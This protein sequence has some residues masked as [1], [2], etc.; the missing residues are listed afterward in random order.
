MPRIVLLSDTH[1]CNGDI[2][3]HAGDATNHG[4]LAEIAA[5]NLW[6]NALPH[7]HK[8]FVAGNHDRLFEERPEIAQNLLHSSIVYLQDAAVEIEGLKIY[9]SPW[10]P[11]FFDWAFNLP[12]GA[13]LAE[14]WALIPADTDILI[15]H[16]PPWGIL[17]KNPSEYNCGC[18]ELIKFV[19]T[20][21]PKLHVFGHIHH[22]YGRL[23]KD[24][25]TYINASNCDES[26]EP[27][28]A[29]LVFDI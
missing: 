13:A 16:G 25:V 21:K 27:T 1:N 4:S 2:L 7:K 5:F 28:N 12:R 29:P 10:Q 24:G 20:I 15:T 22:S 19:E 17:D 23:E 18:E 8:I 11:W 26:Y 3:I 14:K 6:F 9:G